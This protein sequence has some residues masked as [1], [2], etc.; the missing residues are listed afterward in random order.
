MTKKELLGDDFLPEEEFAKLRGVKIST[1]QTE[2][3]RDPYVGPP[4]H[5]DGRRIYYSASGFREWL[6]RKRVIQDQPVSRRRQ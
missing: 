1:L 5:P 3:S 4:F 2:R 6:E